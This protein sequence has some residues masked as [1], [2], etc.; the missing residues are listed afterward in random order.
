V[1]DIAHPINP[2]KR[3]ALRPGN[4]NDWHLLEFLED[5]DK[6]WKIQSPVQGC[7]LFDIALS[8]LG[9]MQIVDVKMNHVELVTPLPHFFNHQKVVG[10]RVNASLIGSKGARTHC[11]QACRGGGIA[12]GKQ[13]NIVSRANQL[14]RQP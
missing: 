1:V 2:W 3:P 11:H 5:I 8:A 10:Q 13:G 6:I 12:A 14:F 4:G 7:N 9:E